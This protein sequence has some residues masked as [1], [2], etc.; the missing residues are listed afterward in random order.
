MAAQHA[1]EIFSLL[2]KSNCRE[3]GEKTCLAFAGA[4][5]TGRKTI[6]ACPYLAREDKLRLAG[7]ESRPV[8]PVVDTGEETMRQLRHQLVQ[9]DFEEAAARCGGYLKNGRLCLKVMGKEFRID[10]QG[11]LGSDIHVNSW[12]TMPLLTYVIHGRGLLPC[13]QWISYREV[14]GGRERYGLFQ[15]RCEEDLR[16]IA[17]AWPDLFKDLVEVFQGEQVA[18]Q[19]ASDIS[20]VLLPLPR[21]PVMICYWLPDEGIDSTLNIFFDATVNDNLGNDGIY[22]LCAG[23][24]TMF[25]KL[26]QRHGFVA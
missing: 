23:L 16:K 14:E 3:C 2:N 21:V 25:A 17:D 4:V 11:N 13:G 12:V 18:S 7:D 9:L 24:T 6:D 8:T 20:V 15:K 26:A 10:R 1:M 5:F 22:T 19:F